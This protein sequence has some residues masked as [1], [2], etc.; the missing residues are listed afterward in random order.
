MKETWL[1]WKRVNDGGND[2]STTTTVP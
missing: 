2:S 1:L